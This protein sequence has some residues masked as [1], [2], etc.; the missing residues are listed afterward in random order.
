MMITL[1]LQ[2]KE[3]PADDKDIEVKLI[4]PKDVSKATEQEQGL[5]KWVV[6]RINELFEKKGN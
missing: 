2:I 3:N 4:T 1:K 5:A 6:E